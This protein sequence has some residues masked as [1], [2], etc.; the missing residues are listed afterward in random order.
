MVFW[1]FCE[2]NK[3]IWET[4]LFWEIFPEKNRVSIEIFSTASQLAG[5]KPDDF[6]TLSHRVV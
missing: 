6:F 5:T 3:H 2:Q 4:E 1:T